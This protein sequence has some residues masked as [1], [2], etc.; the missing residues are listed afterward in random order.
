MNAIPLR[1]DHVA[2]PVHD[3]K[4]A[5]ELFA[6]TL[7]LPLLAA[8][9]GEDW[10]GKDW[11]MMIFGLEVDGQIALCA[12]RGANRHKNV[13]SDLPHVALTTGTPAQLKSWARKLQSHGFAVRHED[14]GDQQ[15]IYFDDKSGLTWEITTA[16]REFSID[17]DA[18]AVVESWLA[19]HRR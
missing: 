5:Y 2:V 15:S 4:A 6:S 1:F 18:R 3:A 16:R 10:D 7:E 11:L 12:L 19:E 9:T 17:P 8:Y 14:H 13:A